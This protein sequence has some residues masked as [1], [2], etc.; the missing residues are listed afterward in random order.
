MAY[1]SALQ[2]A[3][4]STKSAHVVLSGV[5]AIKPSEVRAAQNAGA[6]DEPSAAHARVLSDEPST[7]PTHLVRERS[8]RLPTPRRV[9][10]PRR[11]APR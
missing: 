1:M 8:A 5:H 6:S 2:A 7:R 9:P 3:Q 10:W 11:C 4:Q